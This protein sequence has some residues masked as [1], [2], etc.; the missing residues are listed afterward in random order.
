LRL[1]PVSL[2]IF[3]RQL[4]DDILEVWTQ[5]REDDGIYHG[6]LE[7]PGGG[8]EAG[9]EPLTAAIREVEEEVGIVL[10]PSLAIPMGIYPIVL[11]A[12]TILLN[13]FLFPEHPGLATLGQWL[14]ITNKNLSAPYRGQIPN[15]NHQIID[16][17]YLS[18]YSSFS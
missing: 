7:F 4:P 12:K 13:V 10:N 17:L 16:D 6:K 3:F 5:V 1:I 8:I 15:P 9:E 14:T 18:L 2:A 11:D